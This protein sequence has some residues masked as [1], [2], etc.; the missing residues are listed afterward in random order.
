[1]FILQVIT[2]ILLGIA[3]LYG[4][5]LNYWIKIRWY[6]YK[7]PGSL[8][9][10]IAGTCGAI[11]CLIAPLEIFNWAWIP[12]VVDIGSIPMLIIPIVCDLYSWG[13]R[14]RD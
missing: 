1:M 3:F 4:T 9:P 10:F 14:S 8:T 6:L 11:A 7:R 5:L 13:R 12:L 2:S